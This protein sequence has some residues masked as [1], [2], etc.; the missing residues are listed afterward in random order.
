MRVVTKFGPV[1]GRVE[2]FVRYFSSVY[3]TKQWRKFYRIKINDCTHSISSF[4]NV[5]YSSSARFQYAS[6][7]KPWIQDRPVVDQTPHFP[8]VTTPCYS[9]IISISPA[10]WV[11]QG[12]LEDFTENNQGKRS[13]IPWWRYGFA[14]QYFHAM[15]DRSKTS[16][17]LCSWWLISWV[18]H[19]VLLEELLKICI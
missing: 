11:Q 12:K 8:Q 15:F 19:L 10:R 3:R 16:N 6:D 1:L 13:I 5:P 9:T 4:R 7:P 17:C 18:T 14:A 2:R